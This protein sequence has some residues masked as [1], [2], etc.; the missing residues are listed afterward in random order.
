MLGA[1]CPFTQ[2]CL[3]YKRAS[4]GYKRMYCDSPDG[5]EL[6]PERPKN[7]GNKDLQ[8][9]AQAYKEGEGW[10]ALIVLGLIIF[11]ALKMFG[12]L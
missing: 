10:G 2:R 9:S 7:A 6:C 3:E 5:C 11:G 8:R 4:T 1:G 12:V